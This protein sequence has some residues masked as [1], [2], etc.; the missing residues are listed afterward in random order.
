MKTLLV[1]KVLLVSFGLSNSA[2]RTNICLPQSAQIEQRGCCYV[3]RRNLWLLGYWPHNMLR[4]D[5]KPVVWVLILRDARVQVPP[6]CNRLH[7]NF[8]RVCAFGSNLAAMH[9]DTVENLHL[10][11]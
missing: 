9:I 7:A 10:G 8:M 6:P 4:S 11:I 1:C 3:P 2:P 5:P